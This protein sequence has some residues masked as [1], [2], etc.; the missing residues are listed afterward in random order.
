MIASISRPRPPQHRPIGRRE[1][2]YPN[3]GSRPSLAT[4]S[5]GMPAYRARPD[6]VDPQPNELR[7]PSTLSRPSFDRG[8]TGRLGW[9]DDFARMVAKRPSRLS[10]RLEHAHTPSTAFLFS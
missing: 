10:L 4:F 6:F 7:L 5:P 9:K 3:D 2:I 8:R 1:T